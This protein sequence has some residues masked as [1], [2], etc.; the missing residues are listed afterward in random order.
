MR[1]AILALALL[2]VSCKK[3]KTDNPINLGFEY[4]KTYNCQLT[5]KGATLSQTLS[6]RDTV[7]FNNDGTITET[8]KGVPLTYKLELSKSGE[9]ITARTKDARYSSQHLL[10]NRMQKDTV[11]FGTFANNINFDVHETPP[12]YYEYYGRIF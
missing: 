1:K 7:V 2:A 9:Y 10:F 11:Y 3:E 4:G 5:R 6:Y 8:T 12:V